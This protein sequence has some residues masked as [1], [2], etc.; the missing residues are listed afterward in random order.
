MYNKILDQDGCLR[1]PGA[2]YNQDPKERSHPV[3]RGKYNVDFP[4]GHANFTCCSL[5]QW[6]IRVY[7]CHLEIRSV[8]I[9]ALSKPKLAGRTGH[10]ED[11]ILVF[12]RNF[13]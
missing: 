3:A 5:F 1:H 9:R 12:S 6:V 7:E 2:S 10:F 13:N 4:A 11:E 8:T